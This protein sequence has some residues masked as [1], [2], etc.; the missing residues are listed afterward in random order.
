MI[1]FKE[2]LNK[3]KFDRQTRIK[4]TALSFFIALAITAA[5]VTLSTY[6]VSDA[7][8][9]VSE[10]EEEFDKFNDPRSIFGNNMFHTLIM[11]VPIIGPVWGIFVLFNTGTIINLI[12]TAYGI[13]PILA[14]LS[15]FFTPVF[16]LEFCV[17]SVAMAQSTIW[18]IQIFRGHG[19][20]EAVR[21]CI[22]ITIC[23]AILLLAAVVEWA[24]I[25]MINT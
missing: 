3:I 2:M 1:E 14:L 7:E 9:Q 15:L 25:N 8:T 16:W 17:Y 21:T 11:F 4:I 12:A 5:G 23:A 18:L 19:K 24:M 10:L 22:L 6:E 13:P 20:R